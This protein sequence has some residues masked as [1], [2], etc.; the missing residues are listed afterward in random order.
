[1]VRS[2]LVATVMAPIEGAVVETPPRRSRL[3]SEMATATVGGSFGA[4][5][6]GHAAGTMAVM[7][8]TAGGM[9]AMV[10]VSSAHLLR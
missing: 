10:G 2:L 7:L 6:S 4:L 9:A 5:G 1:M 3:D 8:W